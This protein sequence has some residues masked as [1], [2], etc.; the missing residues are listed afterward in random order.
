VGLLAEAKTALDLAGEAKMLFE[1]A[2]DLHR[3]R[4][5]TAGSQAMAARAVELASAALEVTEESVDS[6]S[7]VPRAEEPI[8]AEDRPA[9]P[10]SPSDMTED[11]HLEA[12]LSEADVYQKYG[13]LDRAVSILEELVSRFPSRHEAPLRPV[14]S[15]RF[16]DWMSA[17]GAG[18]SPAWPRSRGRGQAARFEEQALGRAARRRQAGSRRTP[19]PSAPEEPARVA[20]RGARGA[21]RPRPGARGRRPRRTGGHRDSPSHPSR[22][23]AEELGD[24]LVIEG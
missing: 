16:R 1:E 6:P 5:N 14:R 9:P 23:A 13:K 18:G 15:S 20:P 12:A 4:G 7:P 24:R 22:P 10:R 3:T 17:I 11:Q 8:I 19:W 21:R 2:A